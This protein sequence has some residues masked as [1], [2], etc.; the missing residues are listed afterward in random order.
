M[1]APK[2]MRVFPVAISETDAVHIYSNDG[3]IWLQL[4]RN[5]PTARSVTTT[6]F[7]ATLTLDPDQATAV[8]TELLA[9][10]SRQSPASNG[11][12]K[13]SPPSRPQSPKTTAK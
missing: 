4:R 6:S 8:A 12:A 7:K 5:I 13:P 11:A 10:A 9:A 2:G 3:H 1:P